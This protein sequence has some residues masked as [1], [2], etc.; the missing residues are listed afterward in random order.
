MDFSTAQEEDG[1]EHRLLTRLCDSALGDEE[2]VGAVDL[3]TIDTDVLQVLC[4]LCECFNSVAYLSI[5][6]RPG[7]GN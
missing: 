3:N 6:H 1:E 7:A 5:G 4:G 2:A